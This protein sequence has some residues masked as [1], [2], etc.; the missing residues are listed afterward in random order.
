MISKALIIVPHPDDE[1]NLAGGLYGIFRDNNIH[2]STLF[3][4][5]GDYDITY[6][7]QRHKEVLKA[8]QIFGY[9]DVIF[10]G[11]SDG[12]P[13]TQIYDLRED[14]VAKSFCGATETCTYGEINEYCFS[15]EGV[16]H[17]FTKANF[18]KDIIGVVLDLQPDLIICVDNDCHYDHRC[19]SML[20]DEAMG[21]LIKDNLDYK[22]II[23]KGFAY[24]GAWAGVDDFFKA[25]FEPMKPS[26]DGRV[27]D[28][29]VVYPYDWEKRIRL[30]NHKSATTQILWKNTILKAIL[31][32]RSQCRYASELDNAL[33]KF[34][35]IANPESCYWLR[36]T[37]NIALNAEIQVSS[38]NAKYLN[39]F[40]LCEP[41]NI[42]S[43]F[44]FENSRGWTPSETDNLKEITIN[45]RKKCNLSSIKIYQGIATKIKRLE[46]TY[47]ESKTTVIEFNNACG[48]VLDIPV[49]LCISQ[50]KIRILEH[51]GDSLVINEIECIE[52]D[53]TEVLKHCFDAYNSDIDEQ[54]SV[55]SIFQ[56]Y[57]YHLI[58][59]LILFTKKV[60][61]KLRLLLTK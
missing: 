46:L 61:I 57:L 1:I 23:L 6:A 40:K 55:I 51:D 18:K 15:K 11:Y 58:V 7:R 28:P 20:F 38:G 60:P 21:E 13:G 37:N 54:N 56:G 26:V 31:A 9:D 8:K 41:E 47:G 32:H 3:C 39:D 24:M 10:L 5:N 34:P 44:Y 14:E 49:Y 16:H 2:V 19:V 50:V 4:T 59:N 43:K 27:I 36:S 52:V 17:S 12:Y 48:F 45:F 22:P 30:R 42:K 25:K 33:E 29:N 53:Q 35:R